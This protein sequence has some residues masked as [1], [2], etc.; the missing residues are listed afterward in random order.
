M[1]KQSVRFLVLLMSC[2]LVGAL[3]H[4]ALGQEKPKAEAKEMT[5]A[6]T[7]VGTGVDNMEPVGA[8]ETFPAATEKVFCFIEANNIP[9]DMELS[10]VWSLGGK[11]VR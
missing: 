3:A 5:L 8:A 4:P 1:R 9:K 6:R 11:E 2:A 7:V 10:F